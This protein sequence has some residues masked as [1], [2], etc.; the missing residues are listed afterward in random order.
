MQ[1]RRTIGLCGPAWHLVFVRQYYVFVRQYYGCDG[2]RQS[3]IVCI[4]CSFVTHN[5]IL[6]SI[7]HD[8]DYF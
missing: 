1:T 8:L 7:F 3:H 4:Q 2:N 6:N 5:L